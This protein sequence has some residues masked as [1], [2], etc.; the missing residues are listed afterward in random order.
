MDTSNIQRLC[1]ISQ[2]NRTLKN[3][4]EDQSNTIGVLLREKRDLQ[5]QYDMLLSSID[6]MSI[7]SN[8]VNTSNI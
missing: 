1:C 6:L 4:V 2:M 3:I 7:T 5:E 8:I